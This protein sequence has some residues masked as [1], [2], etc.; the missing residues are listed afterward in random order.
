MDP[1]LIGF[2]QVPGPARS[3]KQVPGPAEGAPTGRVLGP[4]ECW[5]LLDVAGLFRSA[6]SSSST[7]VSEHS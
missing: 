7:S 1:I 6:G 5:V 2:K 3:F 4:P